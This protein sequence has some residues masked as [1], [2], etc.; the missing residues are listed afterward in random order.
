MD[1]AYW[2]EQA[3]VVKASCGGS[4]FYG[5]TFLMGARV[6]STQKASSVGFCCAQCDAHPSC[7]LQVSVGPGRAW[8]AGN[9]AA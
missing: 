5:E 4:S 9:I 7:N 6:L 3:S 8:Q 1:Q 2:V